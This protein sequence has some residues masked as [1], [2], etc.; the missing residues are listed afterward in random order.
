M[1]LVGCW[2]GVVG[3]CDLLRAVRDDVSPRRR[4]LLVAL[5]LALLLAVVLAVQPASGGWLFVGW[6]AALVAWLLGSARALEGGGT[7]ARTVATAG[8]VVGV[9]ISLLVEQS[10]PTR[11]LPGALA[12][13][14]T[15]TAVT[16]AG[17]LLS[18]LATANVA[19]RMLLDAVG[20][21][22]STNEKQLKGGRLLGPMERVFLVTLGLAGELT[23]AG[24][25]VAAKGLLRFPEL[26]RG[27]R[28][29]PSDL[30]EY[31]L[32]GSFASWLW[33]LGGVVLVLLGRLG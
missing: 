4:L 33:A 30:T 15:A 10:V 6:A 1:I 3:V 28:S 14:D 19:I 8:L 20:V 17:V 9:A 31:F 18:Q 27:V 2:L 16:V 13:L 5:G 25:V 22:A 26:Q 21:P 12:P 11:T 32:I 7:P 24:I 29:G 23:A